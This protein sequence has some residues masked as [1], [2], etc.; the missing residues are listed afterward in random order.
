VA[1]A[2]TLTGDAYSAK[3][4]LSTQTLALRAKHEQLEDWFRKTFGY[5]FEQL[6]ES[7]ARYL[8]RAEDADTIRNRIA[9]ARSQAHR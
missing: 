3:L 2:T 4:S 8:T 5:G 1:L 6:T 7:E 9:A